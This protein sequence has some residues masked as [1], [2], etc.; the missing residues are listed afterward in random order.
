MDGY[1]GFCAFKLDGKFMMAKLFAYSDDPDIRPYSMLSYL[2]SCDKERIQSVYHLQDDP[3][4]VEIQCTVFI[5]VKNYEVEISIKEAKTNKELFW[6][7]SE[8]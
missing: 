1:Y 3:E 7:L 6:Y 2:E 4:P 8:A 5:T